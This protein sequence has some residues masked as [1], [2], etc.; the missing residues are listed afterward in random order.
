MELEEQMASGKMQMRKSVPGTRRQMVPETS[1]AYS[2]GEAEHVWPPRWSAERERERELPGAGGS[3]T[4][5]TH[6]E[7]IQCNCNDII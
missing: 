6:V 2:A 4:R 5:H 3:E 7:E 1:S